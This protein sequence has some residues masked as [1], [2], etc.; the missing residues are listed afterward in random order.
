[1]IALLLVAGIT[2]TSI[3]W[4]QTQVAR[5]LADQKTIEV[6]AE[7]DRANIERDRAS[8]EAEKRA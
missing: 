7:K 8:E 5:K 4:Y 3:G 1:M 6:M 2:G